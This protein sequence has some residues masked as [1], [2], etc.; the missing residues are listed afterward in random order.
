MFLARGP[1]VP[2]TTAGWRRDDFFYRSS[3]KQTSLTIVFISLFAVD[4]CLE[5]IASFGFD[6]HGVFHDDLR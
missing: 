2:K 3:F 1:G 5:K 4:I 6:L